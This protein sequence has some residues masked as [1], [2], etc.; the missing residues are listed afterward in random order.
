MFSFQVRLRLKYAYVLTSQ[1]FDDKLCCGS[2]RVLLLSRDEVAVP[3]GVGAKSGLYDEVS[4]GEP[5]RF[6]LDAKGLNGLPHIRYRR[7]PLQS[8][9]NLSTFCR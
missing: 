4:I 2:A 7:S 8:W 1:R 9:Q 6:V 5:F 3:E